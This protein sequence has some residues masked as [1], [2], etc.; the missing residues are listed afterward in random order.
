[1]KVLRLL[2]LIAFFSGTFIVTKAQ[3]F[4]GSIEFSKTIGPVEAKYIYHVKGDNIRVEELDESGDIQGIMLIDIMANKV[5][6]L[7]PERQ[8]YIDVPNRRKAREVNIDYTK[9]SNVKD[10]HGYEC[11]EWKVTSKDDGRTIVYWVA[12]GKFGF[13]KG[14]LETLNRKDKMAVL[15]LNIEEIITGFPME[16]QEVKSDGVELTNLKV[17]SIL[18]KTLDNNMFVI[19]EGYTKFERTANK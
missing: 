10:I 15:F 2:T 12:D 18:E 7:S 8:M 3:T 11:Q 19:P 17:T 16:G 6:A 1:M 5:I 9:T 14:M 13:F 4:E